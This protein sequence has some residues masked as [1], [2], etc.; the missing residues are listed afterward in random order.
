MIAFVLFLI[1]WCSVG[2]AV[3]E[4]STKAVGLLAVLP[5]GGYIAL[6]TWLGVGILPQHG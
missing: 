5:I 3:C 6:G 4:I 1:A 2:V